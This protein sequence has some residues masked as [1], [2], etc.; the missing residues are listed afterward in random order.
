MDQVGT[1]DKL[2]E[3]VL[4]WSTVLRK[5]H[6]QERRVIELDSPELPNETPLNEKNYWIKLKT[7][8]QN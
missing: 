3:S 8:N 5:L 7:L 2:R 6:V 4:N 1:R